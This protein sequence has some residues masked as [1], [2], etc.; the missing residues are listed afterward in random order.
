MVVV[1]AKVVFNPAFDIIPLPPQFT[2]QQ[3]NACGI[4]PTACDVYFHHYF[5]AL[6]VIVCPYLFANDIE[7]STVGRRFTFSDFAKPFLVNNLNC[8]M[9]PAP[10]LTIGH[11]STLTPC[12][13]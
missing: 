9:L 8:Q 4:F 3:L 13:K 6:I 2:R 1:F 5:Y 12:V 7:L 11:T 10:S